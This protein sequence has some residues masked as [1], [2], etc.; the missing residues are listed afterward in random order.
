MKKIVLAL[1]LVA[2]T[3]GVFAQQAPA[4]KKATPKIEKKAAKAKKDTVAKTVV[5]K[6]AKTAKTKKG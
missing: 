2:S 6:P 4:A 5:A 3:V 1:A